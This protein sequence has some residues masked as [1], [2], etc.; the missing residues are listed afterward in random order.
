MDD[1]LDG[2]AWL[3]TRTAQGLDAD[4]VQVLPLDC[5]SLAPFRTALETWLDQHGVEA[6]LVRPDR[7]VFGAGEA[8]TLLAAWRKS[9]VPLRHAA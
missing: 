6:A 8:Q 3:V 5:E 7:Y 9:L 4:D 1:V 2:R